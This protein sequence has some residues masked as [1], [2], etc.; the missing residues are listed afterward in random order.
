[1][2]EEFLLSLNNFSYSKSANALPFSNSPRKHEKY[3]YDTLFHFYV[4]TFPA[5]V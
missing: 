3:D 1:M 4:D 5:P 2:E